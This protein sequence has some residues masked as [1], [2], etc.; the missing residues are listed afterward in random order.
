MIA[1]LRT[2]LLLIVVGVL[3]LVFGTIVLIASALKVKDK[4]GG[5]Y[6]TLPRW[7]SKAIL[8]A[9]GTKVHLHGIENLP[10][11]KSFVFTANH[12]SLLDIPAVVSA[13]PRHYFI[14]KSELFRIPVFGPGIRAIGTIAIERNNQKSA[15][16]SYKI[17]A[18]RVREGSSV[19]VFP[20]GT[21]GFSYAIRPFKKGPFVLALQA[22]VPIVPCIIHGTLDIL[23][24]KSLRLRRMSEINVHI[25]KPVYTEGYTYQDRTRLAE[26][27]QQEM[28]TA[29]DSIYCHSDS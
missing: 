20:E 5:V 14:A 6:D 22:G 26:L 15:F 8:W 27:V 12:V 2:V 18:D 3:T 19:V 7:W 9:A 10:D 28:S 21:R 25:L 4:K 17:A 16:G 29:M 24:K 13:L 1:L 11:T 23:P